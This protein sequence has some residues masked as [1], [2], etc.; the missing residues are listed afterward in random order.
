VE[1][2]LIIRKT[3]GQQLKDFYFGF[4]KM[5]GSHDAENAMRNMNSD[6]RF[7]RLLIS[8]NF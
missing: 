8:L 7:R 1:E 5:A 6:S 3:Q 4:V 2:V